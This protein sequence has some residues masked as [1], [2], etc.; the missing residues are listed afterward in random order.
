MPFS[1]TNCS[2]GRFQF[3][4]LNVVVQNFNIWALK[5]E[6]FNLFEP[7]PTTS[8]KPSIPSGFTERPD[9]VSRHGVADV[10]KYGARLT[11]SLQN[12]HR[13]KLAA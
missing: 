10:E 8:L 1:A 13:S 3:G 9:G 6:I 12:I 4:S 11:V 7:S 2:A 5:F